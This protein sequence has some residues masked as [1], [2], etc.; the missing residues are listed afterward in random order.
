MTDE[1]DLTVYI[2]P[3][4]GHSCGLRS[5]LHCHEL[6]CSNS[7]YLVMWIFFDPVLSFAF[8]SV[9]IFMF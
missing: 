7:G 2:G 3:V 1:Q 9:N 4:A 8:S 6:L 5:V